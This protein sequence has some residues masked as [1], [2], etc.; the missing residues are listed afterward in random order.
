MK[1]AD[2]YE[3]YDNWQESTQYSR[4]ASVTDW[5]ADMTFSRWLLR[6]TSS[7]TQMIR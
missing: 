4:L 6:S 5:S 1:W 2:Y 7:S 3:H